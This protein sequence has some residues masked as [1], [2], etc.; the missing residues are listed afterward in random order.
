ML[1]VTT[2]FIQTALGAGLTLGIALLLRSSPRGIA[3]GV[4]SIPIISFLMATCWKGTTASS[5]PCPDSVYN[6]NPYAGLPMTGNGMTGYILQ[7]DEETYS[8][9]SLCR[10]T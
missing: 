1:H 8:L 7:L 10:N 2:T 6:S 9:G 4:S 5:T 3:T